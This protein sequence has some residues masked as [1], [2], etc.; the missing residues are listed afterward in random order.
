M[1]VLLGAVLGGLSLLGGI[2]FALFGPKSDPSKQSLLPTSVARSDNPWGPRGVAE[3]GDKLPDAGPTVASLC[4]VVGPDG[5]NKKLSAEVDEPGMLIIQ[6]RNKLGHKRKV[7]GEDFVCSIRG[8]SEVEDKVTDNGDGTYTCNFICGGPSGNYKVSVMLEGK[9]LKGSPFKLKM[10]PNKDPYAKQKAKE[11]AAAE[12]A[13]A[14]A[15]KKKMSKKKLAAK[16][17]AKAAA[18]AAKPP[19]KPDESDSETSEEDDTPG[20]SASSSD[21]EN[22]KKAGKAG[23]ST[24]P[25]KRVGGPKR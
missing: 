3:E 18:K 5:E 9:S 4:T 16:K 11:A 25:P 15:K 7:G 23:P 21:D 24:T 12:E 20:T 17:A 13:R 8:F 1:G 19:K 2:L 22:A 14:A 6:A 10:K